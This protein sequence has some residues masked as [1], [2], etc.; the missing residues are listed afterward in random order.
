MHASSLLRIPK[1]QL[2]AEQPST[3]ECWIPPKRYPISKQGSRRGKFT[4]RIKCHTHQRCSEGSNK[5]LYTPGPRDPTETE[6]DLPLSISCGGT[7]QQWPAAGEGAL[8][9]VDLGH[10]AFG[11]SPIGGGHH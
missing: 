3:G 11:I 6:P 7:G 8:G 5:T 2:T 10:T 9:E 4:F 1:L